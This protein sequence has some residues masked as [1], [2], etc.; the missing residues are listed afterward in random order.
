MKLYLAYS[1][2]APNTK[3]IGVFD[4][5]MSGVFVDDLIC[6]DSF[7]GSK[8]YLEFSVQKSRFGT[9]V[10]YYPRVCYSLHVVR[11]PWKS[12]GD[13]DS[14]DDNDTGYTEFTIN[15]PEQT[16]HFGAWGEIEEPGGR[17]TR[18]SKNSI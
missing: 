6:E 9:I 18:L 12:E 10:E 3:V 13:F 4:K 16:K 8:I 2:T 7:E 17:R 5:R 14:D 11:Q 1:E 15:E